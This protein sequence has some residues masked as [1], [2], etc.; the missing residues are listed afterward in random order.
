MSPTSKSYNTHQIQQAKS[1]ESQNFD[2]K[3]NSNSKIFEEK[4]NN[5]SKINPKLSRIPQFYF[6][7]Q[8]TSDILLQE[9]SAVNKIFSIKNDILTLD[10]F[11][12]ISGELLGFPKMLN[13]V[14]FYKID[15]EKTG[16]ITKSQYL[17]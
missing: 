11:S 14:L 4:A 10:D 2:S 5:Y 6:P 15:S 9:E 8:N 7:I 12:S 17:K 13:R 1:I 16:K 3:P